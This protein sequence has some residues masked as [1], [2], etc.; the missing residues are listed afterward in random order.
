VNIDPMA[1]LEDEAHRHHVDPSSFHHLLEALP[2]Q[3]RDAWALG[4]G[5]DLGDLRTPRRVLLVGLGG[6]AIGADVAATLANDLC[7]TPIQVVRNYHLPP[8]TADT[9][10]ILCSFSGNTEETLTAFEEVVRS[11]A[12]GIAITTGGQLA[13]QAAAAAI[14]VIS[15]EW[16][17]PPRTGLGF[18]VFIPLAILRRL[19]VLEISD[20][21]IE[22]GFAVLERSVQLYGLAPAANRAKSLASWLHGGVPAIIGA[23]MLEV[24]AR[25]WAGEMSENAKQVAAAYGI[26]E[27][28]HNQLE[29]A[30][31]AGA[32]V[33]PLRFVLLDAP[34]VHPRNRLRVTQTAEMLLAAGRYVQIANAGGETPIEA[35]LASASLG[36]W[37]SYYLGLLREVDP[38]PL[39]VMDRLKRVLDQER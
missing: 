36:S 7:P 23:D 12:Q 32:E 13:R 4:L 10:V 3:A 33:G 21:E 34:P 5:A 38:A 30:A 29:A 28:N 9:L 15:Y 19:G 37:T 16:P 18:G 17:G 11:D 6:S 14:P 25:R 8:L 22:G 35:L 27:F 20:E 39:T 1:R 24:A 31:R 2:Q 26:P